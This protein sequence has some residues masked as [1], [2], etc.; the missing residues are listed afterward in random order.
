M[1]KPHLEIF[2]KKRLEVFEK[3]PLVTQDAVLTGG[4]ALALQ[5]GHRKSKDFDLALRKPIKKSFL[6]KVNKV[7]RN[8]QTEPRVDSPNE[9]TILLNKVIKITYFH[10][11]FPNLHALVSSDSLKLHSL[12]DIAS[13]KAH[14]I[15]RRGEWRDYVDLYFLLK[16][17]KLNLEK[18]VSETKK[19]F[20]GE[21]DEKLF[22]QQL[23]YWQDLQDFNVAYLEKPVPKEKIQG[24]FRNLV[25]TR[26]CH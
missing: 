5:I 13:S 6:R 19:R 3:L 10:F 4:T 15:G 25:K 23:V 7:F 21:F 20:R 2:D 17:E 8:Y 18:I 26:F 16:K 1:L 9:L 24:F 22:W 11:P 14:T 12:Y